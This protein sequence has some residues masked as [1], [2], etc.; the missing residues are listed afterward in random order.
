MGLEDASAPAPAGL[1]LQAP[2][3]AEPPAPP[4]VDADARAREAARGRLRRQKAKEARARAEGSIVKPEAA[5][6]ATPAPAKPPGPSPERIDRLAKAIDKALKDS[7]AT[8]AGILEAVAP[9]NLSIPADV[10]RGACV[11]LSDDDTRRRLSEAWAP[12]I[13]ELSPEDGPPSPYVVAIVGT[14]AFAAAT[15]ATTFQIR[16]ERQK[17]AA[18]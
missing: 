9:D 3:P 4:P 17:G 10:A 16:A 18:A 5:Q 8:G 1:E 12:L 14:F 13:A 15:A 6:D 2:P 11:A 7:A